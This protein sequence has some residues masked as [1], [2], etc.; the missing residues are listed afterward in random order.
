MY[1]NVK[2][3]KRKS[4]LYTHNKVLENNYI[5]NI[6]IS[7]TGVKFFTTNLA[8]ICYVINAGSYE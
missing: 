3:K 4:T 6:Y 5:D 8:L 2:F 7:E 1:R